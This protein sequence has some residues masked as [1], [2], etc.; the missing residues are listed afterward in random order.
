VVPHQPRAALPEA[1]SGHGVVI[2]QV[3]LGAAGMAEFEAMACARP[4]ISHF[5]YADAYPDPPP[6]VPAQT[7]DEIAAAVVRLVDDHELRARVGAQSRAWILRHH[8]L[9]CISRRVER[10]A[11]DMLEPQAGQCAAGS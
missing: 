2:G 10:A 8:D 6:F 5:S 11:L 4:V 1:I 9:G 3:L 7:A